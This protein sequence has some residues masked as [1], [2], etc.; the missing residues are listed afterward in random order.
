MVVLENRM[1]GDIIEFDPNKSCGFIKNEF[2]SDVFFHMSDFLNTQDIVIGDEVEFNF[3][4]ERR[5]AEKIRLL[6]VDDD[7]WGAT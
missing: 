2:G 7:H 5:R 1:E 6:G 4:K 3:N